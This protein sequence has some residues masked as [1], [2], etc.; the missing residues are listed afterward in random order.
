MSPEAEA[1]DDQPPRISEG[2]PYASDECCALSYGAVP[3]F[4][5]RVACLPAI[6]APTSRGFCT[7]RLS[8]SRLS[9]R[10]APEEAPT[11]G[12]LNPRR[13]RLCRPARMHSAT[14]D[15]TRQALTEVGSICRAEHY[16][17]FRPAPS[18][19]DA[20]VSGKKVPF[21]RGPS[22]RRCPMIAPWPYRSAASLA[23]IASISLREGFLGTSMAGITA[24]GIA[25]GSRSSEEVCGHRE[26]CPLTQAS[27]L[28]S[29]DDR[30]VP[31]IAG[32]GH[33][34]HPCS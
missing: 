6:S 22:Y 32:G 12:A 24:N 18:Q 2:G 23:W 4:G 5:D 11:V 13:C 14:S 33:A 1:Q 31:D 10:A 3:R 34:N 30:I 21:W 28:P 25:R 7:P 17:R 9:D 27:I 8:P 20:A 15:K 16:Y 26:A 19:R 29:F